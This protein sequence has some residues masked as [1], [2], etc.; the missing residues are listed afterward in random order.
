MEQMAE[1]QKIVTSAGWLDQCPEGPPSMDFSQ[2]KPEELPPSQWDAA[3][4][5]KRQQVLAERNKALPAQS[6]NKSCKDPN[7]NDVQIVD[8]SYLQK[9]FKVQLETAQTLIEDVIGKFKLNSEQERAF[10][11]VANHA[12][13]PG[14]E[15]LIMY[16]GGMGGTGKSQ[17]IKALMD[18]FKSRNESHRFVVLA[19]TGTAAAL[20]HGSTYHSFLGVPIDGQ[21]ALR[22]ETTNNSLVK[23]RLDGAEYIFLDEVSMVSCDDNYKISAQLAKALNEFDLPYGG[24]NMIFSGDF[25]QLSPVFGSALYSGTVGTQLMSRM[26]VQGQKAAIG[27]ALWHQVTTIVILRE[28]MRQKTQTAEDNKLRTA[29]ENMR[30]AACTHEDIKFLKTRIAGRRSD[31]PKLSDKE[32]RNVSIITSLNVQKD[33]INELGSVRFAAETGQTLTHFY[34]IDRFG[35]PP[36]VAEKRSKSKKSKASAK[37]HF[38]GKLSLCIGMPVIIRNNDATELCITK[39]QEGHVV[40]WQ[41]GRGIHGQCVLDTL[42]IKL[43]KPAKTVK[44]DGLPENV[45]PITRGSKNIECTFSSDLKEY[46]HRSQ[47]WVLLNFSMTDYTSQGKTRPKNPVDL[48]NCRSHQSYYTCLSRSATANGTVIVQSFSPRLITCGASGYLRQEFREL[49]LLD[50]I[51]K[52]RYEGELP[53]HIQGKFRNPLIRAYQ[54][55]KGTE[56][57]PPITH[58]ALKWSV[59]DPL[60]LLSVVTDAPWQIIDKKKKQEVEIETPKIQA[61][62]VAAKDSVPVTSGKKRKLEESENLS[63][64]TKKTKGAQMIISSNVSSPSG[65]VWDGDNYS[66]AYDALFTILYEIWSTDTKTWKIRFREIN[67]HHLK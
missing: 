24:I 21:P 41:A 11:I 30:Y 63:A 17:V 44:I 32:I 18:F 67:Q 58:P 5:E 31:Q 49:E 27:K 65:L 13:T 29:L 43:D 39:G 6:M 16:V 56:Y 50:E 57:V 22:N 3:V 1:I 34:S 38:S 37:N 40:G 61:G 60:P 51:T 62:F 55:W 48:S 54:K 59:Q 35:S 52:L 10:R 66:C 12:V 64:S 28:N 25:A 46:I 45:V 53:D 20:L 47:V 33:R 23:A 8:R 14:A 2:I 42:F 7:Q 19:P 4:Q 36:D 9:D 26:T 15:Q